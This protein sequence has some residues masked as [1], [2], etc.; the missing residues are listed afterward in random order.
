[1]TSDAI[2]ETISEA[3]RAIEEALALLSEVM[4]T[5]PEVPSRPRFTVIEGGKA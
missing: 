3:E 1:M 5:T 4:P 2:T